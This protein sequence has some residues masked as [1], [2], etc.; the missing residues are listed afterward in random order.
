MANG[1]KVLIVDDERNMRITLAQILSAAGHRA[2]VAD[3]GEAAVSLSQA[4]PFDAVVMDVRMTGM[5]GVEAFREIRRTHP[6]C[7]FI[8]MSAYAMEDLRQ[9]AIAEGVAA[10]LRKPL[11]I[12]RLLELLAQ[13][14]GTPDTPSAAAV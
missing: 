2:S 4:E 3:S 6:G 8:L 11:D 9:A 13:P 1:S 5:N 14:G 7:R 12:P 10:F